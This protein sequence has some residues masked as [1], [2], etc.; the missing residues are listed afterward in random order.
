MK[1]DAGW[2]NPAIVLRQQPARP[3][4]LVTL[5]VVPFIA[6]GGAVAGNAGEQLVVPAKGD[7]L[8]EAHLF[9]GGHKSNKFF[10]VGR[11]GYPR[12]ASRR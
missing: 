4:F 8:A 1:G 9:V 7:D 6:V 11:M 5:Q 10:H 3:R 2:K 12:Y